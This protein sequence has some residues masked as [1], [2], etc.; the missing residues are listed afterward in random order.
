MSSGAATMNVPVNGV[1]TVKE[2]YF[3]YPNPAYRV[4]FFA[5][6][7]TTEKAAITIYNSGGIKL[8]TYSTVPGTIETNIDVSKL[9]VGMYILEYVHGKEKVRMAFVRE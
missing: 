2:T 1:V 8:R 7:V 4:L 3:I 9:P 5:H 6:P